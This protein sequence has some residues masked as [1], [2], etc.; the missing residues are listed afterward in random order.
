[1]AYQIYRIG[2][3]ERIGGVDGYSTCRAH[4]QPGIYETLA[5]ATKKVALLSDEDY[6]SGG[7]GAFQVVAVGASPFDLNR[8]RFA[9]GRRINQPSLSTTFPSEGGGFARTV[10]KPTRQLGRTPA[11]MPSPDGL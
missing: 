4:L 7:D 5:Y 9:R 6:R 2:E 8:P 11:R 3:W 1:M 10:A